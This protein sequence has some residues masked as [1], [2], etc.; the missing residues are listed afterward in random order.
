LPFQTMAG[1][2]RR[3]KQRL[4]PTIGASATD[5][6]NSGWDQAPF[7]IAVTFF[8]NFL[9][10]YNFSIAMTYTKRKSICK[11]NLEFL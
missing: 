8:L 1:H 4:E 9:F 2:D 7:Q 6:L 10:I 11:E 5:V 3:I